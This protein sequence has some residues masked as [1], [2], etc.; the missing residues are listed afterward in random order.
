M[1]H[2]NLLAHAFK[3]MID[4]QIQV[5]QYNSFTYFCVIHIT[6]TMVAWDLLICT[7]TYFKPVQVS[8]KLWVCISAK[9][10]SH[11]LTAMV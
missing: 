6:Y 9:S 2:G 7:P 8:L 3:I 10:H 11:G 5:S 4:H 1:T